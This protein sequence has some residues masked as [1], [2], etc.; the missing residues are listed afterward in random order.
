MSKK[1]D[2]A[3]IT[4][5]RRL[6]KIWNENEIGELS[7]CEKFRRKKKILYANAELFPYDGF[8]LHQCRQEVAEYIYV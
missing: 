4:Q 3:W 1:E 8:R 5:W 6:S 2:S 7:F